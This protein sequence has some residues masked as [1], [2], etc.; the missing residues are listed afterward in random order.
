MIVVYEVAPLTQESTPLC[1]VMVNNRM[2]DRS[3]LKQL[4]LSV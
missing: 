2:R 1:G 4:R 3:S